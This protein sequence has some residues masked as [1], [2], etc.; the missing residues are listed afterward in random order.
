M[1]GKAMRNMAKAWERGRSDGAAA[2]QGACGA[3]H[4]RGSA[5]RRSGPALVLCLFLLA[6]ATP[7][8]AKQ[9]KWP[10]DC[11]FV[12]A[13]EDL[14]AHDVRAEA[15]PAFMAELAAHDALLDSASLL[16]REDRAPNVRGVDSVTGRV[17]FTL[18]LVLEDG[19]TLQTREYVC[20]WAGLDGR[21]RRAVREAL[22]AYDDLERR[23]DVKP[24]S[25]L[26]NL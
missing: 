15:L 3:G 4:V 6:V 16:V 13:D 25:R 12:G 11:T 17:R 7:A 26:M 23:H 24:G 20:P 21:L 10:V 5:C 19:V 2:L 14:A 8:L 22:R 18:I 9:A 1:T